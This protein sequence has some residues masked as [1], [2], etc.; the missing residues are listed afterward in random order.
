MPTTK[1]QRCKKDDYFFEKLTFLQVQQ[2]L[3]LLRTL[4]DSNATTQI[5]STVTYAVKEYLRNF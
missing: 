4:C 1:T 2:L 3:N 5:K